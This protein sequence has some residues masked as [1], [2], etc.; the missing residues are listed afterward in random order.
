VAHKIVYIPEASS[1]LVKQGVESEFTGMLRTLIS[2]GR[3][4][5]QTVVTRDDEPPITVEVLKRGPIACLVTSARANVEEEL[6]TRM[7][8]ADSDETIGQSSR[9]MS[10]LLGAAYDLKPPP[11][12]ALF[13]DFQRWL[14]LDGPYEVV[15]PYADAI[16]AAFRTTPNA[17]RIR[18]DLGNMLSG[19][20]ASAIAHKAQREVDAAGRIKAT[21]D[22]YKNAYDAF[23]PG[24]AA[25]YRPQLAPGVTA[26]VRVLEAMIETERK[27][28]AIDAAA[29]EA[30]HP[31]EE[32]PFDLQFDESVKATHNQLLNALGI[33]SKDAIADRISKALSEGLI[34]IIDSGMGKTYGRRY[35]VLVPSATLAAGGVV[36]VFPTVE[37][38]SAMEKDPAKR[39]A[40]LAAIAAN[41]AAGDAPAQPASASPPPGDGD[42]DEKPV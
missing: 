8:F 32:L 34:E 22:D 23:A 12:V 10:S 25:V 3:I 27:R 40:A 21:L 31:G 6:L 33:A 41:E 13:R 11:E 29:F 24:L 39:A 38:V 36:S 42:E 4:V 20:F 7:L 16:R 37:E 17:I 15:V 5:H 28:V 14:E 19:V 26:L 9:V 18:R 2:E 30:A 35:R 1:L